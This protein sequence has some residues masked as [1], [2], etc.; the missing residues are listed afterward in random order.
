MRH[1]RFIKLGRL[2]RFI[3]VVACL[4]FCVYSA[5]LVFCAG[6]SSHLSEFVLSRRASFAESVEGLMNLA[7]EAVRLSPANPEAH[8]ARGSVLARMGLFA[9]AS[10]AFQQA[11]ECRPFDYALWLELGR[12]L[13]QTGNMEKALIAFREATRLAPYHVQARWQL[14]NFL[15]RAGRNE[16]AFAEL[17]QAVNIEPDRFPYVVYLAWTAFDGYANAVVRVLQPTLASEHLT[18]GNFFIEQGRSDEAINQFRQAGGAG[19]REMRM[20]LKRLLDLNAFHAAYVLWSSKQKA[21]AYHQPTNI[22]A[23]FTNESFEQDIQLDEIGFGWQL[24][25]E[26]KTIGYVLDSDNPHNG[27]RSLRIDF[28]GQSEPSVPIVS[29]LFLVEPQS[30]YRIKF[31]TRNEELVTGALPFVSI[32]EASGQESRELGKSAVIQPSIS[33]WQELSIEFTTGDKTT[34]LRLILQRQKC[35]NS[36]C[37]IYGKVWLD[38]FLVNKVGSG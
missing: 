38:N 34:A 29:Q 20:A 23:I 28:S 13:E 36:S 30:R 35:G 22:N 33:Q 14:G 16:E 8:S 1:N 12:T 17:R 19:E 26:L 3:V 21:T 5:W 24:N 18:L 25:R 11:I 2:G 27:A 32:V 15:L 31:A 9:E 37:P 10:Q 4:L 7:N 6:S